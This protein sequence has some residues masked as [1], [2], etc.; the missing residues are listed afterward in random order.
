MC[1]CSNP[2]LTVPCLN[3]LHQKQ[4]VIATAKLEALYSPEE[5]TAMREKMQ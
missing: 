4:A 3:W 5:L 1:C 2:M